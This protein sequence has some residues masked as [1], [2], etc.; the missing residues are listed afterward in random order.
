MN[1]NTLIQDLKSASQDY[2][3][4]PTTHKMFEK[5][6]QY[7]IEHRSILDIGCGNAGLRNYFPDSDYFA[8]EKSQILINRLPADVFVLGTDFN[9]CTL[10]DK[11]VDMIFCNPP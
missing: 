11:K 10:I 9:C 6:K 4:Y 8:I 3:F 5:V 1:I 7:S 2:E